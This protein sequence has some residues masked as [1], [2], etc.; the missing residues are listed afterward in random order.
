MQVKKIIKEY[1]KY[2]LTNIEY[3]AC[4]LCHT[5][6]CKS[7]AYMAT[8]GINK[9]LSAKSINAMSGAFF[10]TERVQR[11]LLS[12]E[13]LFPFG[14]SVSETH[15]ETNE[16]PEIIIK[17]QELSS[18]MT[19]KELIDYFNARVKS[20]KDPNKRFEY[21]MKILDKLE[22]KEN[23]NSGDDTKAMTYLPERCDSCKYRKQIDELK[24]SK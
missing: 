24:A 11:C 1:L 7:F 4:V 20:V 2:E 23:K 3:A 14:E 19:N 17:G 22:V 10:G 9:T 8:I 5:T 13:I 12:L 15:I 18:N 21:E 16:E 6:K